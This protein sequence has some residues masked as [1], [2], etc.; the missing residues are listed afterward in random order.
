MEDLRKNNNV[1][2]K[3][4]RNFNLFAIITGFFRYIR[5]KWKAILFW[6]AFILIVNIIFNPTNTAEFI[7]NWYDNFIGTII[8]H[9]DD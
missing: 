3:E 4:G 2:K 5:G 7:N 9:N 6:A 1:K 8:E